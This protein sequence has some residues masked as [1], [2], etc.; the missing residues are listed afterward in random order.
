MW[1]DFVL[2]G[3]R[4]DQPAKADDMDSLGSLLWQSLYH[5]QKAAKAS[6]ALAARLSL[7]GE[8][9][10]TRSF[11]SLL[12]SRFGFIYFNVM[13]NHYQRLF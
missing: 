1:F 7:E 12:L 2:V 4:N 5:K 8:E 13:F 11:P 9:D 3:L 10:K 6:S